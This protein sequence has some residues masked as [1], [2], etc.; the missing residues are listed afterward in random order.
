M[1]D[2]ASAF[3]GSRGSL[4]LFFS[5]ELEKRGPG[6]FKFNNPLLDDKNFIEELKE[7]IEKYKELYRDQ[8]EN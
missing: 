3:F 1:Q 2:I 6:F 4:F 7:N 5:K 8:D